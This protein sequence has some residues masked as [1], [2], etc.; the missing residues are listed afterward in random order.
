MQN[1]IDADLMRRLRL[2]IAPHPT[3]RILV[4]NRDHIP[5]EEVA[6][7]VALAIGTAEFTISCFGIDLSGF[8]DILGVDFL[9][10]FGP[11]L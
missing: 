2:S 7:D 11:I 9:C 1:F 3:M 4:A 6:R 5:C 8:D 10:M